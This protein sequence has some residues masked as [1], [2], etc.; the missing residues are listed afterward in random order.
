[1]SS[2]QIAEKLGIKKSTFYNYVKDYPDFADAVERGKNKAN[3][4]VENALYQSATKGNVKAQIFWLAHRRP[5]TWGK[6]A[7][8]QSAKDDKP[9]CI[10]EIVDR[11]GEADKKEST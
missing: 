9:R 6:D 2:E 4:N 7:P 11:S 8:Q 5:E 10:I 1:M 3:A